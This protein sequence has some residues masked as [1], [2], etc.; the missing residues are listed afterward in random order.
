MEF[1]ISI[2]CVVIAIL[3]LITL[4]ILSNKQSY[5]ILIIR[6]EEAIKNIEYFLEKKEENLEKAIPLI[7]ESNKRKY[8]KKDI[9][10][11]LIKN[12][13]IKRNLY[14][15]DNSLRNDLKEFTS[16]LE[17][18][19]KLIKIKDINEVYFDSIEIE[20]DLNASKKYYNKIVNKIENEFKKFPK[21]I[22]KN[23]LG[24]KKYEKFNVKKEETL[25]ILK[26]DDQTNKS[27]KK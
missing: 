17:D 15:K 13:N 14:E 22:L 24:Y 20:N 11:N 23:I 3:A 21:N 18:D 12:K 1:I 5:Q 4:I 8:G 26:V 16:L 25:E 19:E 7:K 10:E 6:M 27:P 9:L 2:I